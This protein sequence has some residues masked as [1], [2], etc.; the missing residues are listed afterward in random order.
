M[1]EPPGSPLLSL[2]TRGCFYLMSPP[3]SSAG[4]SY[5]PARDQSVSHPQ[6]SC[7]PRP[8]FPL[9]SGMRNAHSRPNPLALLVHS[10]VAGV[11]SWLMKLLQ[12]VCSSG[13]R[14]RTGPEEE[15]CE[16]S[17][18]QALRL[19]PQGARISVLS[20]CRS[21]STCPAKMKQKT[22]I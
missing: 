22:I 10:E 17:S 12:R 2:G 13:N 18:S 5:F 6:R 16:G 19:L 20:I 7:G 11:P 9:L 3:K 8:T 14:N 21:P 1:A 15:A 4:L